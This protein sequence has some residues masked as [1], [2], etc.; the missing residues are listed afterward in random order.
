MAY[1]SDILSKSFS[2]LSKFDFYF[3]DDATQKDSWTEGQ[4]LRLLEIFVGISSCSEMQQSTFCSFK[5]S[6]FCIL[7]PTTFSL[8]ETTNV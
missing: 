4:L 8:N 5:R 1:L 6:N 3:I 7:Y 2:I